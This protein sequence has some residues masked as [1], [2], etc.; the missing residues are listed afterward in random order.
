MLLCAILLLACALSACAS[1]RGVGGTAVADL[2]PVDPVAEATG[3]PE[4]RIGPNDLLK[5]TVFRVPE[6]DRQVRVSNDG[7]ISLP[8]VG[9]LAVAGR[10]TAQVEAD[11]AAGYAAGYL[12]DPQ[13][14]VFVDEFASQRITVGG[15]VKK[16]GIY[17]IT[18]HLTLLQALSL[19][20]GTNDIASLHN[21]LVFRTVGGQRQYARFDVKDIQAGKAADPELMGEDVV[22]VDTSGGKVALKTLIQLTPLVAV[23]RAYR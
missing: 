6:L 4:Y 9:A 16:P 10:T 18:S 7:R 20:E 14:S 13:V 5:V 12:R 17:P 11:I 8:L 3:R 19:A 21:V 1:G 23:W 2:P 22:V 15:E